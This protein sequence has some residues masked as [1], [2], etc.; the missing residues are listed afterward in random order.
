[1]AKAC[2]NRGGREG[3][4]ASCGDTVTEG[5]PKPHRPPPTWLTKCWSRQLRATVTSTRDFNEGLAAAL[6]L[7]ELVS[8][9][10]CYLRSKPWVS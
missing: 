9:A 1:M 6:G 2:L 7:G 4:G 5:T 8:L 3:E 10:G